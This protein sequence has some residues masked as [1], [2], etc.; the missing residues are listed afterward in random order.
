[1][2]S[3]DQVDLRPNEDP[4]QRSDRAFSRRTAAAE[5]ANDNAQRPK[6]IVPSNE[7]NIR[8]SS[9]PM[10]FTKGLPHD[11]FGRVNASDYEQFTNALTSV[12]EEGRPDSDFNV[13]TAE[14]A[15]TPIHCTKDGIEPAYRQWESP[16]AGH[17]FS[18]QGPDADAVAMAP[19]PRLGESELTAEIAELYAM[20]I[21]RDMTFTELT[22]ADQPIY[23]INERG[24]KTVFRKACGDVATV[25][26]LLIALNSLDWFNEGKPRSSL[27]SGVLSDV[28]TRHEYQRQAAR[29]E[30]L[31]PELTAQ[32]LFRGSTRGSNVGHYLS[33]FLTLG[34][35]ENPRAG[36]IEFGAQ[37]IHQHVRP[38][39][40]GVDYMSSWGEWLDVQNGVDLSADYP[41]ESARIMSRP[42]DLAEYVHIDQLYQAYFN[43]CLILLGSHSTNNNLF[44]EGFPNNQHPTR[45]A[46]ATFGAPHILSLLTEV[47]TRALK[48]VRRQKFQIH[49]RA[50][51]ERLAALITLVANKQGDALDSQS[52]VAILRILNQLGIGDGPEQPVADLMKWV[53]DYNRIQNS[54]AVKAKRAYQC[55]QFSGSELPAISEKRN[56]LLPMAFAEGSPMHPSYGAGHATVAGACVT[57]LKAFF[58]MTDRATGLPRS[59]ASVS[60]GSKHLTIEGELNKLASNISIGRNFAG[61]HFYSDYYDSLRMGERIAI[62]I[63]QEQLLN[64]S[65]PVS[66]RWHSF[67]GDA[68]ALRTDGGSTSSNVVLSI[69]ESSATRSV[70]DWWLKHIDEFGSAAYPKVQAEFA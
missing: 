61:V 10:A 35:G 45:G 41:T 16:L 14:D 57:V 23:C 55:E 1:M 26:D 49:R 53:S 2:K 31:S 22:M 17:Y 20:A 42:R 51:P 50:R 70:S 67:D 63:L 9:L 38:G 47:A 66:M 39:A 69:N 60:G 32:S 48:A 30:A 68:L 59:M 5:L 18:L 34:T 62:G 25:Q 28:L 21:T 13:P 40:R 43:A 15:N 64:Y 27:R 11:S 3:I 58:S 19:A 44:D 7:D 8:Y 56:Y 65:E 33:Q 6:L 52:Q 36:I 54:G 24:T 37:T 4:L 12:D 46:F 29:G